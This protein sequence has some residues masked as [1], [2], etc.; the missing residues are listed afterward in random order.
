MRKLFNSFIV[1]FLSV[2]SL[3]LAGCSDD[4]EVKTYIFESDKEKKLVN[5]FKAVIDG[6]LIPSDELDGGRFRTMEEI[7]DNLGKDVFTPNFENEFRNVIQHC[8]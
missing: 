5:T 3:D 8:C 7:T 6:C 2:I 4:D 1:I